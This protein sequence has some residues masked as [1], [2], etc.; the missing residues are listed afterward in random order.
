MALLASTAP[1]MKSLNP[2]PPMKRPISSRKAVEVLPRASVMPLADFSIA[3][4]VLV[5]VSDVF[6]SASSACFCPFTRAEA[7]IPTEIIRAST[8]FIPRCSRRS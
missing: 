5:A 1:A 3:L 4:P 7:S 8:M 2:T 6:F